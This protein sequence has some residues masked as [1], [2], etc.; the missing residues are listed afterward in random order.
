MSA[1]RE[2]PVDPVLR[3]LAIALDAQQMLP[4][5][6]ARIFK[7]NQKKAENLKLKD[8]RIE[9][10]K[11][12]PDTYCL[13]CYRLIIEDLNSG[14][15][16][17]QILTGRVYREERAVYKYFQAHEAEWV[18]TSR[19]KPLMYF[20]DLDMVLWTF[21][22]DRRLPG[23]SALTD[24]DFLKRKILPDLI[25][26][27]WGEG[28][29]ISKLS[30]ST[31]KYTPE[32]TCMVRVQME[33]QQSSTTN[34]RS[35]TIYGK[36]FVED[37]G[38]VTNHIM[39]QLWKSQ[40]KT[41]SVL[42]FAKPL[43]YLSDYKINWQEGLPGAPLS[44]REWSD[45]EFL[46]LIEKSAKMV[47]AFHQTPI[48]CERTTQ[49]QV[50]VKK[51]TELK[52]RLGNAEPSIRTILGDLVDRLFIQVD[53]LDDSIIATLHGD[54][55]LK[56]ILVQGVD[57]YL[58]DMD[59]ISQG[60]P[61][62]DVGNFISWLLFYGPKMGMNSQLQQKSI[63]VFID[64]Y[65]KSV[66]WE[67]SREDLNWHV[68]FQLVHEQAERLLKQLKFDDFDLMN[69]LVKIADAVNRGR[70]PWRNYVL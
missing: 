28:W 46:S 16:L 32:K 40:V 37:K 1:L 51:L 36:T 29:E 35:W 59:Q 8:C 63:T 54:L 22:N 62:F 61:L 38:K 13:I 43:G 70:P 26:T 66:P 5:F 30:H 4:I 24:S 34:C 48:K 19:I 65:I 47:A 53:N 10:I 44:S 45:S 23:L 2:I 69:N 67:I 68:S 49:C 42:K 25:S 27:Y 39:R 55:H 41:N 17:E 6:Q 9:R 56:N 33:L 7:E 14:H 64:R 58:I 3:N 60:P 50:V 11:H 15:E 31:V 18:D 57:L 20:D 52:R 21:P 12:K